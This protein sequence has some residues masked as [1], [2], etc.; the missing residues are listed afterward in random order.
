MVGV[1][2]FWNHAFKA[3]YLLELISTTLQKLE[4]KPKHIWDKTIFS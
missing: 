4:I 3:Q 1:D 2:S